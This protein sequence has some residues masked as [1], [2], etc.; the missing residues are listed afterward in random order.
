M[1]RRGRR[2]KANIARTAS[3]QPSR[4]RDAILSRGERDV[5]MSQ[6]HR[7][8]LPPELRAD[9]HAGCLVGRLF[10]AKQIYQRE[11]WAAR[12]YLSVKGELHSLLSTPSVPPC[13]VSRMIPP[14]NEPPAE[15]DRLADEL[16]IEDD[17][18][19]RSRVLGR[20]DELKAALMPYSPAVR[21]ALDSLVVSDIAVDAKTW[22]TVRHAL[23]ALAD[24][25]GF[26]VDEVERAE[27]EARLDRVKVRVEK[28][29][30][31]TD[32]ALFWSARRE[33]KIARREA[34]PLPSGHGAHGLID[35]AEAALAVAWG[36]VE[37]SERCE[38]RGLEMAS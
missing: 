6:P 28:V 34:S 27:M 14:G 38:P 36:Y 37:Q 17:E 22:P 3:G 20:W 32:A 8:D 25:W 21:S 2:K 35:E 23:R 16:V 18:D 26:E 10:L 9:Q 13:A 33:I 29:S 31:L 24:A 19:R 7:R 30:R 1:A 15:D 11:E 5:A 12:R 4:S